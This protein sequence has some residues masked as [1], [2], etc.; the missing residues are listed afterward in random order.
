MTL[1]LCSRKLVPLVPLVP[2]WGSPSRWELE[3]R[4]EERS[5]GHALKKVVPWFRSLYGGN[6][7][8]ETETAAT[9]RGRRASP[10]SRRS[11]AATR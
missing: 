8:L 2:A 11:R 5:G 3:N 10:P 7:K 6:Q 1:S 4:N 9:P